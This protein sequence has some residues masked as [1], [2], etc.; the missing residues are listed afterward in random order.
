MTKGLNFN[1]CVIFQPILT[2]KTV[3][4]KLDLMKEENKRYQTLPLTKTVCTL[5]Y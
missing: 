2:K 3:R 4:W 5:F 1:R